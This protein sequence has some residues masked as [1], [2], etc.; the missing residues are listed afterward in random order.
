MLASWDAEDHCLGGLVE[1]GEGNALL[2]QHQAVAFLNVDSAVAGEGGREGGG[3][4]FW[5]S[6]TPSVE[7][8]VKEATKM[9]PAPEEG[10]EEKEEQE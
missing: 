4:G 9:V 7:G 2:L 1:W 8:V 5:A 3:E 10:E 6:A